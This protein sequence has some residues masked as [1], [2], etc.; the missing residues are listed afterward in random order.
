MNSIKSNAI[1]FCCENNA[2]FTSSLNEKEEKIDQK[3]IEIPHQWI[4]A[5]KTIF[6]A[7]KTDELKNSISDLKK[8]IEKLSKSL[9]S[10]NNGDI[11]N[12][13][14]EYDYNDETDFFE[15]F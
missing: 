5:A 1:N 6:K 9:A 3:K 15:M 14:F 8:E 10:Q 11:F 2:N 12:I 4:E 7:V 13:P